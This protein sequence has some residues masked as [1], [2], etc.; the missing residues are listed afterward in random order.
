MQLSGEMTEIILVNGVNSEGDFGNGV[1]SEGDFAY[2]DCVMSPSN[3]LK[4]PTIDITR[5]DNWVR[6]APCYCSVSATTNS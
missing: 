2:G 4:R 6:S 1:N 5:N 3:L